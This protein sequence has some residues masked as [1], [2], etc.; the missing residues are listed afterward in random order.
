MACFDSFFFTLQEFSKELVGLIDA[1]SR[2]CEIQ[3][4]RSHNWLRR[5]LALPWKLC[6]PKRGRPRGRSNA[7]RNATLSRRICK[8]D[9]C[10][11]DLFSNLTHTAAKFFIPE[12]AHHPVVFPKVTPHAPNTKQTPAREELTAVERF[13]QSLW[14]FGARAQQNDIKYAVKVGMATAMLAAP[15]FFDATRPV[16]VEY[17]GEWAL[18]S[19]RVVFLRYVGARCDA[20][21]FGWCSSLWSFRRLLG[22]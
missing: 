8:N 2:I 12:P 6:S 16:F 21:D 15:A 5:L 13:Y 7:G 9:S 10:C 3:Q 17:R 1:M 14:A 18:I 11:T 4:F 22:R 20:D 19:V